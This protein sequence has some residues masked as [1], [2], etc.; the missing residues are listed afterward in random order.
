MAQLELGDRVAAEDGAELDLG[1][2]HEAHSEPLEHSEHAAEEAH[3]HVALRITQVCS[4][5]HAVDM[6]MRKYGRGVLVGSST[7]LSDSSVVRAGG[8]IGIS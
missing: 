5:M 1:A 8:Q 4:C 7:E 2:I 3:T 6:R